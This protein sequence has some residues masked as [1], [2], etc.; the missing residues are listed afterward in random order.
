MDP[1]LFPTDV[2]AEIFSH[3]PS[4]YATFRN[5]NRNCSLA[6]ISWDG[7]DALIAQGCSVNICFLRPFH[8]DPLIIWTKNGVP[9]Q[10]N[11]LPAIELKDGTKHWMKNGDYH[12][13]DGLPA[14]EFSN[15]NKYWIKNGKKHR[16]NDLPAIEWADG[17]KEWYFEGERH[18]ESGLPAVE[19]HYGLEW[20]IRGKFIRYQGIQALKY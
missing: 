16:E 9:H 3:I 10:G 18:R 1:I 8:S 2:L 12:R 6:T 11:G 14:S 7:W 4:D 20:W 13:E 19:Y 15:G 17:G 5:L